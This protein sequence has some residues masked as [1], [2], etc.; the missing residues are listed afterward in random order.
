MAG[1]A[2]HGGVARSKLWKQFSALAGERALAL[3]GDPERVWIGAA[4]GG[5][6]SREDAEQAALEACRRRRIAG[7]LQTPC[8]LY[9]VGDEIVW[10]PW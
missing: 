10:T 1:H 8:R 6:A 4:V 2:P 5:Q 3:S 7:R 9:A